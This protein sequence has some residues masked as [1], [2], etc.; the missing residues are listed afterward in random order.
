MTFYSIKSIIF[1][2]SDGRCKNPSV[3]TLDKT[4]KMSYDS[5][6]KNK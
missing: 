2:M 3:P 6:E 1:I 5:E 4:T